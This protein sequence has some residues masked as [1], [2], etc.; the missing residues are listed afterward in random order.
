MEHIL[1]ARSAAKDS[2]VLDIGCGRG[3][4]LKLLKEKNI[5]ARGIDNTPS[6]IESCKQDGLNAELTDALGFLRNIKDS[7]L[8]GVTA[9][10]VVEHLPADYLVELVRTAH[11]KIAPGGVIVLETVNPGSVS[12]LQN[13]Y[14]DL[15][16]RNPI[17][18]ETLKFLAESAGFREVTV[19][20]LRPYP[21][22]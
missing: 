17:P 14:L 2:F 7:T 1:K 16:H 6:M 12:S 13:F 21:R 3:E 10:Q 22:T 5:S 11:G 18:S 8:N 4:F 20:F 15:T 9:F 19:H